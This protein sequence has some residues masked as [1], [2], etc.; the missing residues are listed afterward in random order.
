[1]TPGILKRERR[2]VPHTEVKYAID[3]GKPVQMLSKG[4]DQDT[5]LT[6]PG[7]CGHLQ[8]CCEGVADDFQP[9][10]RSL[11]RALEVGGWAGDAD[12]RK[13]HLVKIVRKYLQRDAAAAKL[14]AV[15]AEEIAAGQC[16]GASA[17]AGSA[18]PQPE[19]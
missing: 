14:A 15:L 7:R 10:A 2:W 9:Y 6:G 13:A 17:A 19:S 18:E 5:K 16:D 1:M 4:F 8:E 3:F 12:L 11:P